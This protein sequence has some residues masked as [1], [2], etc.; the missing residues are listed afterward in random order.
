MLERKKKRKRKGEQ[1][2]K[3]EGVWIGAVAGRITDACLFHTQLCV[4]LFPV[5]LLV[6]AELAFLSAILVAVCTCVFFVYMLPTNTIVV[7]D[8]AIAS[9]FP[10]LKL[11]VGFLFKRACPSP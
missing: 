2:K 11:M 8:P 3:G 7:P 5:R 1:N 10:L 4:C 6:A 9:P